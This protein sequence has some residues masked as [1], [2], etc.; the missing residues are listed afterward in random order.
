MTD[1]IAVV[2][3][4]NNTIWAKQGVEGM[5]RCL[6]L[7]PIE[8]SETLSVYFDYSNVLATGETIT[9]AAMTCT[10]ESGTDATPSARL[11][12]SPTVVTSPK[13]GT[14]TAAV[15][16]SVGTCVNGVVYMLRCLATTSGGQVLS[17]WSRL[18]CASPE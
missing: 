15:K 17:A 7:N 8:P 16:Q 13:S 6:D 5:S 2:P 4:G 9:S 3:E 11:I 12:S 14:A 18:P 1:R 10:V